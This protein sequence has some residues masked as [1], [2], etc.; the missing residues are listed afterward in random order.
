M[1]DSDVGKV[2]RAAAVESSM[3]VPQNTKD[4]MIQ[5]P[6]LCVCSQESEAQTRT[7]SCAPVFTAASATADGEMVME[8]QGRVCPHAGVSCSLRGEGH[9]DPEDG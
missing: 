4:G 8:R 5:L 1:K 9:S 3:A 7:H 2:R 6:H